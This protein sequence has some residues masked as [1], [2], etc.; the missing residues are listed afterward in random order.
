MYWLHWYLVPGT[1]SLTIKKSNYEMQYYLLW[2][3]NHGGIQHWSSLSEPSYCENSPESG[4]RIQNI[5]NTSHLSQNRMNG[6]SSST[7]W[8][9]Q[10]YSDTAPCGCPQSIWLL[11]ITV[12]LSTM[13]CSI[14]WMALCELELRRT[15]NGR[16]AYSFPWCLPDRSCPSIML[17]L[18]H[19]WVCFWFEH[20][21]LFLSR[22]CDHLRSGT[23]EWILILRTRLLI[24]PNTN[25][26]F[27]SMWRMHTVPNL[28]DCA[29][30][31]T[32]VYTTT[33]SSPPLWLL[34]LLNVLSICMIC[35]AMIKFS[36]RLKILLNQ[37][38]DKQIAQYPYWQ[39][40]G[41][42]SIQSLDQA[43]TWGQS[44]Q[45][46]MITTLTQ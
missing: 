23:R 30:L 17:K 21:S 8:K 13:T 32:D 2:I 3:W 35:A 16:K 11:C 38:P 5:V 22:S 4:W 42:I 14:I 33:I 29:S 19:R 31:N 44:I 15:L 34:D 27:W 45:M 20:T 25:R 1:S 10:G 18:L 36:Y 46:L 9:I 26:H 37:H 41:F 7:S 6:P 43:R 39:L 12:S 24:P 28:D 40:Q